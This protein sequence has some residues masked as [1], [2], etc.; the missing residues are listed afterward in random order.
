[1]GLFDRFR[2][3]PADSDEASRIGLIGTDR[4]QPDFPYPAAHSETDGDFSLISI[5]AEAKAP[6]IGLSSTAQALFIDNRIFAAM[7]AAE[8]LLERVGDLYDAIEAETQYYSEGVVITHP[9]NGVQREYR[10]FAERTSLDFWLAASHGTA[11]I[12]GQSYPAFAGDGEDCMVYNLNPKRIAVGS[13]YYGSGQRPTA[14]LGSNATSL[15][16]DLGIDTV[17]Q[18]ANEWPEFTNGTKEQMGI[19]LDPKRVYHRSVF[20]PPHQRYAL[21]PIIRAWDQVTDR[22]ILGEMIRTNAKDLKSQIRIWSLE[23]ASPQ[24][25]ADLEANLTNMQTKRSYDVVSRVK[26]NVQNV[27]PTTVAELL[28]DK[29]WM[30]MTDRCFRSM[31]LHMILA[32]GERMSGNAGTSS[33]DSNDVQLTVALNRLWAEMNTNLRIARWALAMYSE[34]SGDSALAKADPP[35]IT[36]RDTLV[37]AQ[38]R[39]RAYVP[40]LQYGAISIRTFHEK[41]GIDFESEIDQLKTEMPLRDEGIIKPYAAF[42]QTAENASGATSTTTSPA[43]PGRPIHPDTD[44]GNS[45]TNRENAMS[46]NGS[47]N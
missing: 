8:R 43:S 24:D 36:Y 25:K 28:A 41:I 7:V 29:T 42:A 2:T 5:K 20:K 33:S 34:Y 39:I 11:R 32:S 30:S 38:Q 22:I 35:N 16:N 15:Y 31:G 27:T 47:N 21:P 46:R 26:V 17:G 4:S 45:Q 37:G 23:N 1:M 18:N 40:L 6:F 14:Y 13:M 3:P 10:N 44:P 9:D 12:Y 19:L